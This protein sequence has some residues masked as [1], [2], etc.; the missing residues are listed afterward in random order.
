MEKPVLPITKTIHTLRI[1]YVLLIAGILLFASI[2]YYMI[3]PDVNTTIERGLMNIYYLF[4][5]IV[6]LLALVTGEIIGNKMLNNAHTKTI[7]THKFK[8]YLNSKIIKYTLYEGAC[9][10]GMLLYIYSGSISFMV[11]TS[12]IFGILVLSFPCTTKV[13]DELRLPPDQLK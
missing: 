13:A 12:F 1:I 5:G 11:L 3:K 2:A 7:L 8:L 9:F 10:L 6:S 4:M